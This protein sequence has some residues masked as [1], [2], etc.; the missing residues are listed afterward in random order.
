MNIGEMFG[1]VMKQAVGNAM[2][3]A[4][5]GAMGN[6]MGGGSQQA[7]RQPNNREMLNQWLQNPEISSSPFIAG[8]SESELAET[9][10]NLCQEHNINPEYFAQRFGITLPNRK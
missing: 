7:N 5:S 10:Y 4:V 3:Q 2:Q 6:I 1:G 8:K 9:F